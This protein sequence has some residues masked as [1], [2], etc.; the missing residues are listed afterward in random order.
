MIM[1]RF[2]KVCYKRNHDLKRNSK[3]KIIYR[4]IHHLIVPLSY[5]RIFRIYYIA[6]QM[7]YT[8]ARKGDE[9]LIKSIYIINFFY[10]FMF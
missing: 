9:S 8:N 3:I 5:I 6:G 10:R 2:V 4:Y 7:E 1:F